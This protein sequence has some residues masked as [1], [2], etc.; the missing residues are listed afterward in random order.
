MLL[1]MRACSVASSRPLADECLSLC[2]VAVGFNL[3]IQAVSAALALCAVALLVFAQAVLM[4]P[5]S[6]ARF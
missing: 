4:T 2:W 5:Y 1:A 3:G 6:L